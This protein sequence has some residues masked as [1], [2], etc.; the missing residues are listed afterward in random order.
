[1]RA[2]HLLVLLRIL[3]ICMSHLVLDIPDASIKVVQILHLFLLLQ[4]VRLLRIPFYG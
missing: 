3:E 2:G 4:G 1:M